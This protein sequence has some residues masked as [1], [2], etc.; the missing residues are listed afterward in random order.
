MATKNPSSVNR[1]KIVSLI[2]IA[3]FAVLLIVSLVRFSHSRPP[4]T[5]ATQAQMES[6]K[7]IVEQSL[8]ANG[9]NIS[10]YKIEAASEIGRMGENQKQALRVTAENDTSR[11]F[12]LVDL[13]TG[14]IVLH[15]SSFRYEWMA[16]MKPLR[17]SQGGWFRGK[18]R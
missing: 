10:N 15:D 4:F 13:E 18:P 8:Q 2:F 17:E 5:P 11:Q 1:W 14:K 16:E 6:A 9:Y 3:L 12:Y 7:A